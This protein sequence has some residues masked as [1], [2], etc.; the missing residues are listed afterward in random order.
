M[1]QVNW[2]G[3]KNRTKYN[4]NRHTRDMQKKQQS[5]TALCGNQGSLQP[6]APRLHRVLF[7]SSLLPFGRSTVLE[8]HSRTSG[9][10]LVVLVSGWFWFC[11]VFGFFFGFWFCCFLFFFK[12]LPTARL[13]LLHLLHKMPEFTTALIHRQNTACK[14]VLIDLAKFERRW[15]EKTSTFVS[16]GSGG[17]L[18][19]SPSFSCG[20]LDFCYLHTFC[21]V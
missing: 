6:E 4:T 16:R 7:C 3:E 18:S 5:S 12:S 8:F 21:E 11:C 19:Y 14:S 1:T 13:L 2:Y 15:R 9:V 10:P 17:I 20:R